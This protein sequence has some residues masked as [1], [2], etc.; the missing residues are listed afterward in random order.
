MKGK[1]RRVSHQSFQAL[2]RAQTL[3]TDHLYSQSLLRQQRSQMSSQSSQVLCSQVLD[4]LRLQQMPPKQAP[5]HPHSL[6]HSQDLVKHQVQQRHQQRLLLQRLP[7][8]ECSILAQTKQRMRRLRV[9]PL[10]L[11]VLPQPLQQR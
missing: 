11:Q 6:L 4:Q 3:L 8:L 1:Q 5:Q 2:I 10:H 9:R 7:R